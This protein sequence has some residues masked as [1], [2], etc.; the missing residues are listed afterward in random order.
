MAVFEVRNSG[1]DE[2]GTS[3]IRRGGD[4]EVAESEDAALRNGRAAENGMVQQEDKGNAASAVDDYDTVWL[5]R[6]S[7]GAACFLLPSCKPTRC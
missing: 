7:L 2:G 5:F 6:A 1:A 3:G 4:G